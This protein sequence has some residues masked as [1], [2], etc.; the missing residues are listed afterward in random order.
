M[1]KIMFSILKYFIINSLFISC[2]NFTEIK[3]YI[4]SIITMINHNKNKECHIVN[5]ICVDGKSLQI[6]KKQQNNNELFFE[7]KNQI[8]PIDDFFPYFISLSNNLKDKK[9]GKFFFHLGERFYFEDNKFILDATKNGIKGTLKSWHLSKKY[10]L[11]DFMGVELFLQKELN[12]DK[13]KIIEYFHYDSKKEAYTI[14]YT[15]QKKDMI[16]TFVSFYVTRKNNEFVIENLIV[17]IANVFC[18]Y[19]IEKFI[20]S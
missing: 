14:I 15:H 6:L 7:Y 1:I 19:K 16:N 10:N 2:N 17:C 9:N 11:S 4:N 5:N 12:I 3:Q 13:N 20:F 8:L 18:L